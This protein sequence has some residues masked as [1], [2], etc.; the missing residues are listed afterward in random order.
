MDE[1]DVAIPLRG[2]GLLAWR[3]VYGVLSGFG[4]SRIGSSF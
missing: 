1:M 4:M 2:L 3:F